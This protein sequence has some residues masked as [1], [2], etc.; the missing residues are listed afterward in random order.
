[1]KKIIALTCGLLLGL[2]SALAAEP[3]EADQKWLTAVE[4]KVAQGDTKVSVSSEA[5]IALLKDWATKNGYTVKV[6][7]GDGFQRIELSK[8]RL[9]QK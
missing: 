4:K 3:S 6:T 2:N 5:R 7:P 1:M 8:T 9:A